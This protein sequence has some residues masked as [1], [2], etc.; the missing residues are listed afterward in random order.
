MLTVKTTLFDE[1]ALL[2]LVVGE[3]VTDHGDHDG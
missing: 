2:L 1:I 3:R